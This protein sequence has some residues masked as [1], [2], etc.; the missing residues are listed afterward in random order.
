MITLVHLF[1][2]ENLKFSGGGTG[3]RLALDMVIGKVRNETRAGAKKVL[4]LI[5]DGNYNRGGSPVES[6]KYLRDKMGFSIYTI[7]IAEVD[8]SSLEQIASLP[9]SRH[10]YILKDFNMLE[11]L[12][13]LVNKTSVGEF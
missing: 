11:K 4:F 10:I 1:P 9:F 6:S 5:T 3:T 7:G 13:E 12:K 2:V 8:R